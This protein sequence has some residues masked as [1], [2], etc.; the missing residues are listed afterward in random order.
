MII[1]K[2]RVVKKGVKKVRAGEDINDLINEN[3][4]KLSKIM[5]KPDEELILNSLRN[6]YVF[7]ALKDDELDFV[8]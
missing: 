6:H 4:T 1:D 7:Y 3:I 2:K 5:S 8:V